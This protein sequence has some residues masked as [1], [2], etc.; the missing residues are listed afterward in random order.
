MT[1]ATARYWSRFGDSSYAEASEVIREPG[2]LP[3]RL[4]AAMAGRAAAPAL[5]SARG[6][7]RAV[8]HVRP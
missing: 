5:G 1:R 8:A 3:M 4:P 7:A 6:P 2:G